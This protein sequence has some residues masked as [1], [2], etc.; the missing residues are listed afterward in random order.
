MQ[1]RRAAAPRPHPPSP[2]D[3]CRDGVDRARARTGGQPPQHRAEVG[4]WYLRRHQ[5]DRDVV[6]LAGD[7]RL[8]RVRCGIARASRGQRESQH[9][10][11]PA[12]LHG[13]RGGRRGRAVAG[14]L[15]AG[16]KLRGG[17]R[18]KPP[19]T[20]APP[21]PDKRQPTNPGYLDKYPVSTHRVPASAGVAVGV[22]GARALGGSVTTFQSTWLWLVR[23][24]AKSAAVG[25]APRSSSSSSSSLFLKPPPQPTRCQRALS[26]AWPTAPPAQ[27]PNISMILASPDQVCLAGSHRCLPLPG[28]AGS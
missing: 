24:F 11:D 10:H 1:M 5:P 19:T 8:A 15:A 16:A 21:P 18:Y 3:C 6:L 14:R 28:C 9:Q 22:G 26:R 4:R 12:A 27:S 23:T 2:V 13:S 20:D 7:R 17:T 25:K